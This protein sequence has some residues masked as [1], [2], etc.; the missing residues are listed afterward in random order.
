MKIDEQPVLITRNYTVCV[1]IVQN[2][3]GEFI[4]YFCRGASEG[5]GGRED[6]EYPGKKF[7][8]HRR[9]RGVETRMRDAIYRKK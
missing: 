4:F 5:V 7:K 1:F 3:L 2:E 8:V 9:R 6:P